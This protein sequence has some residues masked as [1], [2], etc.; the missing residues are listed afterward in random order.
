MKVKVKPKKGKPFT[1]KVTKYSG[2]RNEKTLKEY[3]KFKL[4]RRLAKNVLDLPP[5][6]FKDVVVSYKRN[7]ELDREFSKYLKNE[8]YNSSVKK[9]AAL[10]IAPFT[11]IYVTDIIKSGEGP[12]IVFTDHPD[13][14]EII[15]KA[16]RKKK[17][18]TGKITGST[19]KTRDRDRLAFQKGNLDVLLCSA[20]AASEG[21]NLT[22][23]RNMVLND[24]PWDHSMFYQLLKRFDRIGQTRKT[25]V[26]RM[27][28]TI[29][30][31]RI[32]KSLS[33]KAEIIN[34]ALG[35]D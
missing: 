16:L 5:M 14:L 1:T 22:I 32:I 10:A 3:M 24:L 13:T 12:V 8:A 2:I 11:A 20:G 29:V 19:N 23:S 26:H 15:E 33:E 27:I 17:I 25:V 35:D 4:I 30:Y 9:Q 28:G 34:I 31:K 21:L 7:P 6:T 18:T